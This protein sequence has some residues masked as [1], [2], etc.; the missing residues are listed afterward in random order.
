M[1]NVINVNLDNGLCQCRANVNNNLF[2]A[3]N[4]DI[5][6]LDIVITGTGDQADFLQKEFVHFL[7]LYAVKENDFSLLKDAEINLGMM[8]DNVHPEF[9]MDKQI[10]LFR[11]E[12][13]G[14]EKQVE[15]SF[16]INPGYHIQM[17]RTRMGMSQREFSNYYQIPL[18]S[19]QQW[20]QGRSNP[21]LYVVKMMEKIADNEE[22]SRKTVVNFNHNGTIGGMKVD[23][24]WASGHSGMSAYDLYKAATEDDASGM[25]LI[26][27]L[28]EGA[29]G[30]LTWHN[31]INTR[32]N[33]FEP[34]CRG[35]IHGPLKQSNNGE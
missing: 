10:F 34:T 22:K 13:N 35:L 25:E 24:I 6:A 27:I 12:E 17:L 14:V 1:K 18:R 31:T 21:P 26:Y 33:T 5:T 23:H 4:D 2:I 3:K 32:E 15:V 29:P 20:E 28:D 9:S 8:Y 11:F 16:I 7:Y 19:L 30:D